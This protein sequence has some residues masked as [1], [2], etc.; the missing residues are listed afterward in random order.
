MDTIIPIGD[1]APEFQLS[2][3]RGRMVSLHDFHGSILVLNFWSAECTW[4]ERVDHALTGFM[5]E[6][7]DRVKVLWIASNAHETQ[8]LIEKVAAER[9]LPIVVFD[10]QQQVANLYGVQTTPHFFIIDS[11]GGLAYQGAW[12]NITF[13]Q[14]VA[15]QLYV[16]QAVR[17]LLKN[18]SPD[19][20][21]TQ[22]YGCVLVRFP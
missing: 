14:R 8:E 11:N 4:C 17:A 16:P 18:L 19:I 7:K 20:S 5:D 9:E 22:P 6:W 1:L 21:Q 3:L 10:E 2:D 12:D 13:R 15:T